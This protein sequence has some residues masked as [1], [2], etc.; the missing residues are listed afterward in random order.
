MV[1]GVETPCFVFGELLPEAL[2]SSPVSRL[3]NV[4]S[5]RLGFGD[6]DRSCSPPVPFGSSLLA[7]V[8]TMTGE[9]RSEST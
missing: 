8:A 9:T 7:R 6:G 4:R 2:I 1:D 5:R 3:L